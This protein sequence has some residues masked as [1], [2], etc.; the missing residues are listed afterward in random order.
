[1]GVAGHDCICIFIA[2]CGECVNK[3]TEQFKSFVAFLSEIKADIK[4]DLV[5]PASAR[6]KPLSC[7]SYSFGQGLLNEGVYILGVG[8][9]CKSTARY[10]FLDFCKLCGDCGAVICG[11]YSLSRKH[12]D[13]S[14]TALDIA[15]IHS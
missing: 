12:G 8:V 10:F 11:D 5:V 15:G 6:M 4:G 3:L 2:L 1:M 7:V 13:M 9:D 14:D